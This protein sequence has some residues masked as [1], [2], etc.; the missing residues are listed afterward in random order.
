MGKDTEIGRTEL[1]HV[2][3]TVLVRCLAEYTTT[4]SEE[5]REVLAR[6]TPPEVLNGAPLA[7]RVEKMLR[8]PLK[9]SMFELD[10]EET[11]RFLQ[12]T[13]GVFDRETLTFVQCCPDMRVTNS[14]EWAWE[15][16]GLSAET[17]S[18]IVKV[19]EHVVVHAVLQWLVA[20]SGGG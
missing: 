18:A 17:E 16:S 14:T 2:I 19:L 13:N 8:A 6:C 11:R 1:L 3:S 10:G 9:D 5:G 4:I 12:F 7:E 15:G 20:P